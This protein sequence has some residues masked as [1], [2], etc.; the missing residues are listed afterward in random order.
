M[1]VHTIWERT[2]KLLESCATEAT[3]LTYLKPLYP[4]AYENNVLFLKTPEDFHKPTII[5]RYLF[6]IKRC[7][8]EVIESNDNDVIIVSPE[9]LTGS[10][11]ESARHSNYKKTNLRPGYLFDTFVEGSG[12]QMAVAAAKA[13]AETSGTGASGYNPLF[14][15]GGVGLGKTHLMHAIGNQVIEQ[16]P[17]IKVRYISSETFTNE[18]TAALREQTMPEFIKRYRDCDLI[19]IDD[20]QFLEGKERTQEEMFHTFNDLYNN[21]KQIVIS[22]DQPPKRLGGLEERLTSRFN[23]GLLVDITKPDYETRAAI[24]E[25]KLQRENIDIPFEVKEIIL[26]NVVTNIRDLEGALNKITAYARLSNVP[27]SLELAQNAL[28]DQLV[29]HAP[30]VLTMDYIQK[31]VSNHYSLSIEEMNSR[32]RTQNIVFPRQ[33]AMYL[34]RKLMDVSQPEVGRFFGGRDH[35][36]VIHSCE[37]ISAELEYDAQLRETIAQLEKTIKGE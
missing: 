14:L 37:K 22:S 17:S 9:D 27:I 15:Y 21:N 32:K 16:N 7:F 25:K 24:L 1:N 4:H 6:D 34:C 36:T 20:I 26:K 33:V 35:T 8:N 12:N 13:V 2:L 30:P 29:D 10:G 11:Q 18:F 31:I 28:K 23:M 3:Y 19:L 5:K